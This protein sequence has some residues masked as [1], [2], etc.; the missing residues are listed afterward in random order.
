MSIARTLTTW[1]DGDA[2][3][4]A[5]LDGTTVR[6]AHTRDDEH[7]AEGRY[8]NLDAVLTLE[9]AIAMA[10]AVLAAAE[11]ETVAALLA[12]REAEADYYDF[13]A[14]QERDRRDAYA[15]AVSAH[16]GHD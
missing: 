10:K 16:W 13:L 5:T 2:Y 6:I 15:D 3:V 11:D 4:A 12:E 9:Q 8:G 7:A 1:Q 14:D